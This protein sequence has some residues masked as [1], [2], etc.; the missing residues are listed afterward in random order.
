M[1]VLRSFLT[2]ALM[3]GLTVPWAA[4]EWIDREGI[5]HPHTPP[6]L[7]H[8]H[9]ALQGGLVRTVGDHHLELAVDSRRGMVTYN[10]LNDGDLAAHPIPTDPLTIRVQPVDCDGLVE[11]FEVKLQPITQDSDSPQFASRFVGSDVKL[12]GIERYVAI[13]QVSFHGETH[14][15]IFAV[16]DDHSTKP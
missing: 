9:R 14:H 15:A 1:R 3:L 16:V 7:N 6:E 8:P 10:V 13:V 11:P 4:A 5:S 2:G 12:R